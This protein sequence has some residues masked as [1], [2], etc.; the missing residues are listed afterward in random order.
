MSHEKPWQVAAE[1]IA[2]GATPDWDGTPFCVESCTHHDGKRCRLLG[3]EP[4][5]ICG[6]VVNAMAII[7]ERAERKS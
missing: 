2:D 3:C 5:L 1:R 6:P 4:G 7:L